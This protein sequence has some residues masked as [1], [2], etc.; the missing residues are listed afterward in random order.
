MSRQLALLV[1]LSALSVRAE[2]RL[3]DPNAPP[4]EV[5]FR[6]FE[7]MVAPVSLPIA[8]NQIGD[9]GSLVRFG[10]QFSSMF[11]AYAAT[12][13]RWFRAERLIGN[14]APTGPDADLSVDGQLGVGVT[15]TPLRVTSWVV[16]LRAGFSL[17]LVSLG[18]NAR[19]TA[20]ALAYA[21][22][23]IRP[24]GNLGLE[25]AFVVSPRVRIGLEVRNTLMSSGVSAVQGCSLADLGN[26]AI[27]RGPPSQAEGLE[28]GCDILVFN[29]LSFG[30]ALRR[31][32]ERGTLVN[33]LSLD[34]GVTFSF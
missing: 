24:T 11:G 28:P 34:L 27:S 19:S 26:I 9:F 33:R 22:T 18:Y 29:E 31:A 20:P 13:A 2:E 17:A 30:E 32:N 6:K 4:A 12:F 8:I 15:F 10:M 23:G 3:A 1:V 21:S 14:V 5:P 25:V 7:L 16:G